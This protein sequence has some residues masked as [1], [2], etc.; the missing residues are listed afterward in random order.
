M[1][2]DGDGRQPKTVDGSEQRVEGRGERGTSA[3]CRLLT[4]VFRCLS[5]AVSRAKHAPSPL[6]NDL[7]LS[8]RRRASAVVGAVTIWLEDQRLDSAEPLEEMAADAIRRIRYLTPTQARFYFGP[9]H[10]GA[11][12]LVT[13]ARK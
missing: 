12:V 6:P 3:V 13:V 11:V 8:A 5:S 1:P 10:E 9:M 2:R 4:A 7:A